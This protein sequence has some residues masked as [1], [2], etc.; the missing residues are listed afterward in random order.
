[1]MITPQP[2]KFKVLLIGDSCIDEYQYGAVTRI[3]PEAPVPVFKYISSEERPGMACNVKN[4]L[5]AFG[6]EVTFLTSQPSR[7]IRLVDK[8]SG[9]HI[10]RIDHDPDQVPQ[11]QFDTDILNGVDFVVVSDYN[12]GAVRSDLIQD[13]IH[14]FDGPVYIDTK[15]TDLNKF[16]GG[17]VKINQ[18]EYSKITS[19]CSNMI[20]T[21]GGEG[22]RYQ[23]QI[24]KTPT[25]SV[26]DVV[27]AGDVFLAALAYWH[28]EVGDIRRAITFANH[29]AAISVKHAGVYTLTSED[30][31][32]IKR[33][34]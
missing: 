24:Y 27:G 34:C 16:E 12:K 31:D 23:G 33:I 5:E 20:V 26:Y 30:I 6:C 22:T 7:K 1:M 9:H 21:L 13:L 28:S 15:K 25:V 29:A 4:N 18:D 17:I 2:R 10:A 11:V 14:W 32:E 19:E 3:S 8:K